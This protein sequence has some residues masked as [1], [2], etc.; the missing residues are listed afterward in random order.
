[1]G[2][3]VSQGSKRQP[4]TEVGM[5]R[6]QSDPSERL[7]NQPA[8]SG[9][10]HPDANLKSMQ[11]RKYVMQHAS[12]SE[13]EASEMPTKK[14]TCRRKYAAQKGLEQSQE[15][16]DM[17]LKTTCQFT[18][19]EHISHVHKLF[20]VQDCIGRGTFGS[21]SK[22]IK[23][24]NGQV[25]ALKVT[26][27]RKRSAQPTH[28]LLKRGESQSKNLVFDPDH[29]D[30]LS[31]RRE[32]DLM[33]TL[34]HPNV[35]ALYEAMLTQSRSKQGY[36]L[37]M[38]Y[39]DG[40][41]LRQLCHR[42]KEAIR[43]IEMKR[44]FIRNIDNSDDSSIR[45]PYVGNM[46][47]SSSSPSH[48]AARVLP[49]FKETEVR[50]IIH[51]LLS[52]V[53]YLHSKNVVHR[54]LKPDNILLS[55]HLPPSLPARTEGKFS[56]GRLPGHLGRENE[57][58]LIVDFGLAKQLASAD[59]GM[60]VFCGSPLYMAPEMVRGREMFP[61]CT[62]RDVLRHKLPPAKRR[63]YTSKCDIWSVGVIMFELLY[64]YPPF[65][66]KSSEDIL[67]QIALANYVA[68]PVDAEISSCTRSL[69]SLLLCLDPSKRPSAR[70]S[71][72][73]PFFH[74]PLRN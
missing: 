20:I 4:N 33:A 38:E 22:A 73:H 58:V 66:G 43:A 13:E 57:R 12:L 34:S 67:C 28:S 16:P 70:E 23:K 35:A 36:V 56:L 72:S 27:T 49:R 3:N 71:L 19:L 39:A 42:R 10:R 41:S 1:M 40:G 44:A 68:I 52:G 62:Y 53:A 64:G 2:A 25:V 6:S 65:D 5:L 69:L 59:E 54:D 24:E 17:E 11:A 18:V 29:P 30:M 51:Q 14:S 63:P 45:L 60:T 50:S 37:A 26:Q 55:T 46:R 32:V 61:G 21:V 47:A 48:A 74:S 31:L 9:Y 7:R 8:V 15:Q